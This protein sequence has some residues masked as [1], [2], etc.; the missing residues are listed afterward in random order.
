MRFTSQYNITPACQPKNAPVCSPMNPPANHP[1]IYKP[2]HLSTSQY[3]HLLISPLTHLPPNPPVS[4]SVFCPPERLHIR[5]PDTKMTRQCSYIGA[6]PVGPLGFLLEISRVTPRLVRRNG[7]EQSGA[8]FC[9]C[10]ILRGGQRE[11]RSIACWGREAGG[12]G[13]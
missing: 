12:I 4:Q 2:V 10:S 11:R 8:S 7:P 3:I 9:S 5:Q 6:W 13:S 1:P